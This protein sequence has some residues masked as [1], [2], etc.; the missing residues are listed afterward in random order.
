MTSSDQV[1][2]LFEAKENQPIGGTDLASVLKD[3]FL[4]DIK[5]GCV[6][7]A[8]PKSILVITV[9]EPESESGVEEVIIEAAN[10]IS[11]D[12]DLSVTIIQVGKVYLNKLYYF[13]LFQQ[14]I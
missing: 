6:V 11:K 1:V 12:S 13:Q 10:S 8:K 4:P 14:I 7:E 2:Q 9:G 3:A 5:S